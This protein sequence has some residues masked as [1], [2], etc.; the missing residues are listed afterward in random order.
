MPVVVQWSAKKAP[1]HFVGRSKVQGLLSPTPCLFEVDPTVPPWPPTPT[2]LQLPSSSSVITCVVVSAE[3]PAS[4]SL[5]SCP[6]CPPLI[7]LSLTPPINQHCEH[8]GRSTVRGRRLVC[9]RGKNTKK[10]PPKPD[11]IRLPAA[12]SELSDELSLSL[13]PALEVF[14]RWPLTQ[15]RAASFG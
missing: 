3:V 8:I 11:V 6:T 13:L 10:I 12:P 9:G 14:A 5:C 4:F 7:R 2:V 1:A 15:C